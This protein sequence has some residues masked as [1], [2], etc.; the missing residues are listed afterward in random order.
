[1][2]ISIIGSGRVASHLALALHEQ[3]Q[4]IQIYARQQHHAAIIAQQVNAQAIDDYQLLSADV[5]LAI[6]AVSD[7]AIATVIQAV[8]QYLPDILIVHTSGSTHI[9]VM[10]HVHPRSG[11]LYPL[12]TFSYG[13]KIDWSNTPIFVES[14][15]SDDLARLQ[16]LAQDL[17]Q[18]VYC[19]DSEQ[20][21]SLHLAAVFA[22]NFSN[23]CYDMAK[24]IVDAQHVDFALLYPLILETANKAVHTDPCEVQTGPAMRGDQNILHMHEN[25]LK[26]KNRSD[27]SEVYQL[28]SQQIL[29]RHQNS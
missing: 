15:Q 20:R 12:Q 5:D 9:Q 2:R 26:E 3:H 7:Q 21:L 28:L 4:I 8:H 10:S 6:I 25:M 13:R 17:S 23:Y 18:R 1:M 24:Q 29:T 11:V 16:Q 27:F 14:I 19:Y 22:F